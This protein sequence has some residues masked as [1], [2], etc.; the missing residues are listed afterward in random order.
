MEKRLRKIF[1]TKNATDFIDPILE[2]SYKVLPKRVKPAALQLQRNFYRPFNFST[3]ISVIT[4]I[5]LDNY[6]NMLYCT[7]DSC[8]LTYLQI[9]TRTYGDSFFE[10]H[11][12]VK[13]SLFFY[14]KN[15]SL[16]T[17]IIPFSE[18]MF[19][20]KIILRSTFLD[21]TNTSSEH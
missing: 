5:W 1:R 15:K 17:K 11:I 20:I 10:K 3:I 18:T 6:V 16:Q 19:K 21:C 9:F 12:F 7:R 8:D 14:L 4:F 13:L 2:S